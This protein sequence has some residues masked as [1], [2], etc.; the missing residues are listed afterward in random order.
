R[1]RGGARA[2]AQP[3]QAVGLVRPA[4]K[5]AP[6]REVVKAADV[7]R[8]DEADWGKE[9]DAMLA[10]CGGCHSGTF[11]KEQLE[12]GDRMIRETDRLMAEAIRTVAGLYAGGVVPK[13]KSY[14]QAFP[15]LLTFH[16][17]PTV[18][19]QKLF[20]M[21]L[22]HRMRAFQGTFHANPDYA[23]S[24]GGSG[25]ERDLTRVK[26]RAAEMRRARPA[27]R[28]AAKPAVKPPPN[29]ER[30]TGPRA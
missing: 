5:P 7:A 16:D 29:R 20:V 10:T 8:L 3:L 4:G 27:A 12:K 11:A 9:R 26:R 14:P 28:P 25:M 21:V 2:R 15:D 19:V 22:E 6:G 23:L 13:P 24:Y 30:A 17:A 1:D 18:I